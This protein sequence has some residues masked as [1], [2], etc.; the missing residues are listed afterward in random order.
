MKQFA[1]TA[2]TKQ[3]LAQ[4]VVKHLL[5]GAGVDAALAWLPTSSKR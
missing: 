3:Q 5:V 4:D 2:A 1:Q